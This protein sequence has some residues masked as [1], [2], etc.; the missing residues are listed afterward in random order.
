MDD[1]P[2]ARELALLDSK[3][4]CSYCH[5]PC[6]ELRDHVDGHMYDYYSDCCGS[7]IEPEGNNEMEELKLYKCHKTVLARP[8][9]RGDYNTYRGWELPAD[10]DGS[11]DGYLV[12]YIDSPNSNHPNHTGYLSWSPSE[13]FNNGYAEVKT[14]VVGTGQ[15]FG[16]AIE[17]IK[18]GNKVRR[19][20]WNG[21]GMFIVY[22]PPI[23]IQPASGTEP[24]PKVNERTVKHI[25]EHTPLDCQPYIAMFNAQKQWIPGWLASQS[26]ML[27][28]DWILVE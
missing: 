7:E 21:K 5:Q 16:W 12:E 3:A 11:D 26:D 6:I 4:V 8:M 13:V 1:R 25:G 14:N 18:L 9:T 15:P 22:M 23:W 19:Q 28:D 10:E 2:T 24:G 27:C 17:Q 20:G